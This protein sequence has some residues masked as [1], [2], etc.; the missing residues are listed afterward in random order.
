MQH[1]GL[2][3]I[4]SLSIPVRATWARQDLKVPI[5]ERAATIIA[6]IPPIT[7]VGLPGAYGKL[8]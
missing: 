6:R 2:V 5:G 3:D 4:R 7:C 1:A 8:P